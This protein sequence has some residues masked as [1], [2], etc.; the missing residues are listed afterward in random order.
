MELQAVQSLVHLP[1]FAVDHDPREDLIDIRE[2]AYLTMVFLLVLRGEQRL[3]VDADVQTP[4]LGAL[5]GTLELRLGVR[6]VDQDWM[7]DERQ[8]LGPRGIDE[9]CAVRFGKSYGD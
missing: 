2:L 9:C 5:K 7:L 1:V 6:L 3:R 4:L 8:I